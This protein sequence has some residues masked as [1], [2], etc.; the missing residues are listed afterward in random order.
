MGKDGEG[1]ERRGTAP[2]LSIRPA[3]SSD[4]GRLTALAFAAKRHWGYP[5]RWIEAWRDELTITES[6]VEGGAFWVAVEE[7]NGRPLGVY[8]LLGDPEQPQLEHLWVDPAAQ[9]G[10][11]GRAL[12]LHAVEQARE[13]GA[14]TISI[15]ADPNAAGF[16]QRMGAVQIGTVHASMEGVERHRPQYVYDLTSSG[17]KSP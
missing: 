16:Y 11:V 1:R 17:V 6:D 14:K 4:A 5:E 10:G 7:A 8:A 13:S 3:V 2:G 12:F 15:D 9:R